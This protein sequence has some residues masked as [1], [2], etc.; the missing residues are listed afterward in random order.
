MPIH[1]V[2]E[3]PAQSPESPE[4]AAQQAVSEAPESV[5]GIKSLDVKEAGAM[6]EDGR[7]VQ[8]RVNAKIT[9]EVDE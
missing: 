1:K 2:I 4:A 7:T 9:F 6:V 8:Y 3:V 5:R